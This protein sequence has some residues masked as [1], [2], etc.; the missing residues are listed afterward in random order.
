MFILFSFFISFLSLTT[1]N[2][3]NSDEIIESY[4]SDVL[5]TQQGEARVTEKINYN[6]GISPHHGIYRDIL[7]T[8]Q[9]DDKWFYSELK[10][11]SVKQDGKTGMY[12]QSNENG[13]ERLKIGDPNKEISGVHEYVISYTLSPI[14][15]QKNGKAFLNFD[16]IGTGWPV[17]IINANIRIRLENN[18][19]LQSPMCYIGKQGSTRI[20]YCQQRGSIL[21]ANTSLAPYQG[22]TINAYLPNQY[23]QGPFLIAEKKRF[24]SSAF[25]SMIFNFLFVT[26]F[27]GPLLV[28][29][30]FIFLRWRAAKKKRKQQIVVP[31]YSPPSELS[32]AE[33][34]LLA[35]DLYDNQ[36]IAATIISLA[37]KGF[38]TIKQ[39]ENNGVKKLF[40]SQYDYTLFALQ[41]D[42]TTL[43]KH[44]QLLYNGL[45]DGTKKFSW[46]DLLSTAQP[47]Q[48][49]VESIKLSE[50]DPSHMSQIVQYFNA[51]V[52]SDLVARGYYD[53]GNEWLKKGTLTDN[54]AKMW[55]LVEG[56]KLFLTVVEKDRLNFSDAPEKTPERFNS[57]LPY[58]V[59]LGVERQW[60][61]EF[62]DIDVSPR[63]SN[64]YTGH[65]ISTFSAATF[66]SDISGS[67]ANAVSS[68]TSVSSSGGSSGSGS[69]GGG[70]GSW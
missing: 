68:N 50:L 20:T 24:D 43:P 14:V 67:F 1:T 10:N 40:G 62:K 56:F 29:F 59:A 69:G 34:G 45:F 9:D 27:A 19:A 70:G 32:P 26:L 47:T 15:M 51:S 33:A 55:A 21:T 66:V 25:G 36:E 49:K 58:A 7:I 44:E 39:E 8:Y 63:T 52:K 11:V 53:G 13:N 30:I 46:S 64:W 22:V 42:I 65:N 12:S 23:I 38:L 28:G 35:D 41:S 48:I 37:V 3:V 16:A 31:Q 4:T 5:I 17:P 57:I 18:N 54:G 2:A 6:L 60:A 61:E